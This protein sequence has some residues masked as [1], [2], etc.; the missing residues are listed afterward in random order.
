[1]KTAGL[2]HSATRGSRDVCSSPRLIAAY[3]G[4]RRLRVPRHPPHAFCRLTPSLECGPGRELQDSPP[5]PEDLI[6]EPSAARA[7]AARIPAPVRPESNCSCP[8]AAPRPT[9]RLRGD[10]Y[11]PIAIVPD[12][13]VLPCC[14]V[15]WFTSDDYSML[16]RAAPC[17]GLLRPPPGTLPRRNRTSPAGSTSHDHYYPPS[18]VK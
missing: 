3:R 4:L 8:R 16:T 5:A 14:C 13:A 17:D 18:V 10:H 12:L 2:P 15:D 6:L 9:T 11:F 7:H 1:V